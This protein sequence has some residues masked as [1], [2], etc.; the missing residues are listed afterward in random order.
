MHVGKYFD[1]SLYEIGFQKFEFANEYI[2][3]FVLLMLSIIL[4]PIKPEEKYRD[5]YG[6]LFDRQMIVFHPI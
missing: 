6:K 5:F 2:V 1:F 3:K 4:V